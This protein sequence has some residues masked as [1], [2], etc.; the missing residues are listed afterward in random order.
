MHRTVGRAHDQE[1]K[2]S[3]IVVMVCLLTFLHYVAAQM[4]GPIIPLYAVAHGATASGV[5][6]IVGAHMAAAA[7]GSIFLGR[8]SDVWGRRPLLLGGMALGILTSLFLPVVEGQIGLTFIYGIAGLG[9]AAFTP[10]ALSIVGDAAPAGKIGQAYA[11]YGTAHYSAI[12]IGPFIGGLVS[13]WGGYRSAFLVSAV[14]IALA[15]LAGIA[16]PIRTTKPSAGASV[17]T[18]ADIRCNLAIWAGWIVALTGMLTQGV[19][20][21]FL[22]L[23]GLERGLGPGPIGFVFLILGLTNTLARYPAG[24][25]IDRTGRRPGYA[26]G[27]VLLGS[28]AVVALPRVTAHAS[29]LTLVGIFGAVSGISLARSAPLRWGR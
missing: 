5:G 22:P 6:L 9:V 16:M 7:V 11:W 23:V 14:G 21:T 13:E 20:Y 3:S 18:F 2:V 27:G 15:L 12:G 1:A 8:A 25:I 17:Y 28:L 26:V 29:L 24:W 4:R 19:V 10:S